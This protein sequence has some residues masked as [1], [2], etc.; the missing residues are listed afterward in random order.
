M[1]FLVHSLSHFLT[2][3]KVIYVRAVEANIIYLH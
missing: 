3:V 2:H 1:P